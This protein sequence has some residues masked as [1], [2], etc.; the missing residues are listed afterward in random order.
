[1]GQWVGRIIGVVL[2]LIGGLWTLQGLN[3]VGGSFMT[4]SALWLVIGVVVVI[5]GLALLF[6]RP[7]RRVSTDPRQLPARRVER[8]VPTFPDTPDANLPPG[9]PVLTARPVTPAVAEHGEGPVW[10]PSFDGVRWVDMQ[11]GD[12][13]ELAGTEDVRRTHVGTVAACFRP[14]RGGGIVLADQRG[15]VLLDDAMQVERRLP[16]VWDDPGIRMNEGGADPAGNFWAG[17]MAYDQTPGAAALYRLTPT[18]PSRRCSTASRSPTASASPPTA[19]TPTTSTPRRRRST[20]STTAT[21]TCTGRRTAFPI[22]DGP[23]SPDGLTVDAEGCLW[24]ALFGGAAVHRYT[25]DGELLAAVPLPVAQVTACTF[26]GP[27]LDRLYITTS[28]EN[29]DADALAAQP[30]AGALFCVDLPGVRGLPV[31]EFAG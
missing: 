3:L 16:E 17:S 28:R 21:A 22:A 15:F 18:C 26:G 30:L 27:E 4:G 9:V 20:S 6:R 13:L 1:M 29:L 25:P 24:V 12:I 7:R 11:A 2:V 5:A 19:P 14:R 31:L 10:H 8:G 23:G